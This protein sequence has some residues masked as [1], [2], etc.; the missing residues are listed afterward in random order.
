MADLVKRIATALPLVAALL[1]VIFWDPTPW[2]VVAFSAIVCAIAHDEYLRMALPVS[3]DD[4]GW[5]LRST[6][7]SLGVAIVVLPTVF[8]PAQVLPPLLTFS[9]V[10]LGF[11]TLARPRHLERA[12]RHYGVALSGLLYVPLLLSVLPLL[13]EAGEA[14][15]LTVTLCMAF[16]SD[17]VAYLFG[18]AFGRH[19]LYPA[20]SPKKSWE[21]SFG[22]IV[23]SV[24]ATVGIGSLWLL[25]QLPIA[26]AVGLG[27]VGSI[28]GQTGDLVESM[29]KRTFGVKDS[30]KLLP[31]HGGFLD[32]IDALLFVAPV[33]YYYVALIA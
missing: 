5:V 22:G 20:V 24:L 27:V 3:A 13:K 6:A 23:G 16:F 4:A 10:V 1:V 2:S 32:R 25:P 29:L 33:S 12:G 18:R 7:G 26:H 15:W 21:G 30:G 14:G 31:G 28:C 11:A 17:T 19:K 9:A 8:T